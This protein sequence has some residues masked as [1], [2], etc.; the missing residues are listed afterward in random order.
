MTG[1]GCNKNHEKSFMKNPLQFYQQL[2]L[3]I[4]KRDMNIINN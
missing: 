2:E 3:I 4:M 1:N